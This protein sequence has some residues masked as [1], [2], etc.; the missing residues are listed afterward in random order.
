MTTRE[1]VAVEGEV[2]SGF[3]AVRDAFEE[4]FMH[5]GEVGGACCIYRRRPEGR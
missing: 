1:R 5:R 4:N 3:D 2:E